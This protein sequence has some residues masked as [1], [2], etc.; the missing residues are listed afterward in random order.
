MDY[1]TAVFNVIW[2]ILVLVLINI[3]P[4]SIN[5]K[6]GLFITFYFPLLLFSIVGFDNEN[7]LYVFY[8]MYK[9]IKNR[10]VY[11]FNKD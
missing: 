8:Y 9:F 7:I 11:F 4:F 5:I 10:K 3:F 1:S 2:A 6:I